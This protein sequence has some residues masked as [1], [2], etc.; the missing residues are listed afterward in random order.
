V[1]HIAQAHGG[2]ATVSSG[3]DV[4]VEFTLSLPRGGATR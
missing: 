3:P 2:E 1:Q 4:G